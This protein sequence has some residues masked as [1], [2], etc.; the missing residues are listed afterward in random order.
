MRR[1]AVLEVFLSSEGGIYRSEEFTTKYEEMAR[2][3]IRKEIEFL[4]NNEIPSIG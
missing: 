3:N 1:A 4:K 2:S